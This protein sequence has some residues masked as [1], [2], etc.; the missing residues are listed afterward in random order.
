M[1]T[2]TEAFYLHCASWVPLDAQ[3]AYFDHAQNHSATTDCRC[4]RRLVS[5]EEMRHVYKRWGSRFAYLD[6][7]LLFSACMEAANLPY[8][9]LNKALGNANKKLAEIAKDAARLADHIEQYKAITL[10]GKINAAEWSGSLFAATKEPWQYDGRRLID[11]LREIAQASKEHT[12]SRYG[13]GR[14]AWENRV[15]DTKHDLPQFIRY[16]LAQ[17]Q[18][19]ADAISQ[20]PPVFSAGDL[21]SLAI[22]SLNIRATDDDYIGKTRARV[23]EL[24]KQPRKQG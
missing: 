11:G 10:D 8:R 23:A 21:T 1:M 3:E 15:Q 2:I 13:V 4:L 5:R 14:K 24:L 20:K 7:A 12:H 17:L 22:A 6:W 16:L 19:S 18:A 9:D